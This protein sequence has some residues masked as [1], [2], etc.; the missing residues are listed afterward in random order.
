VPIYEFLC[1]DCGSFEQQRPLTE[2]GEPMPCPSCGLAT[3]RIYHMPAT[4]KIPAPLSK[5]M[6]RTEKS[7]HEPEVVR[8]PSGGTKYR[9]GH[10]GHHGH[11]H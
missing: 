9:A 11:R 7:V 1:E 5:A 3:R 8:Q 4:S 10:G 6:N 2:A